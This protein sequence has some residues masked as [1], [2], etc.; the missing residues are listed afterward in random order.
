MISHQ[1]SSQFKSG[2]APVFLLLGVVLVGGISLLA[3][4]ISQ[5]PRRFG[6]DKLT[7]NIS[8]NV[9]PTLP[10]T[11]T[12]TP[13]T[14]LPN[15]TLNPV[16]RAE[17]DKL[18][19]EFEAEQLAQSIFLD[20]KNW[21]ERKSSI[22]PITYLVPPG[23]SSFKTEGSIEVM[24]LEERLNKFHIAIEF[25]KYENPQKLSIRE[26]YRNKWRTPNDVVLFEDI[27]ISGKS[28]VKFRSSNHRPAVFYVQNNEDIIKIEVTSSERPVLLQEDILTRVVSSI[29]FIN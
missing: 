5:D 8:I 3:I 21:K 17:Q 18:Q 24:A 14:K 9:E 1:N 11:P 27:S 20:V 29:K 19:K 7:Q 12:P 4:S 6:V 2:F 13:E 26:W 23:N 22:H 28:G 10:P 15:A 25:T 16:E